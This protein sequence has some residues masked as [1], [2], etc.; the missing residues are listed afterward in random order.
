M[1]TIIEQEKNVQMEKPMTAHKISWADMA[2]D[3]ER[4][5]DEQ[6]EL[7]SFSIV[8]DYPDGF[9]ISEHTA[10]PPSPNRPGE[11]SGSSCFWRI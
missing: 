3:D 2:S 7:M 6:Q 8:H 9:D 4:D 11:A 1:S 5:N 10:E